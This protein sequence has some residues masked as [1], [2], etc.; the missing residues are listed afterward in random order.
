MSTFSLHRAK[1]PPI[2]A[3]APVEDSS[4][5]Q[6]RKT[7]IPTKRESRLTF[8]GLIYVGVTVFLAIGA[9][10]SQNNLLFWLF[11]VSIATLIV[12]GIF[13]GNALM[14][15]RVHARALPEVA[16]GQ[17]VSLYYS[18]RNRSR[19]FPLFACLLTESQAEN[20]TK[21]FTIGEFSPAA[22]LHLGPGQSDSIVG[23]LV[24]T[25]R[26]RVT[27]R[28][29]RLTT[30]FPFGLLQKSLVFNQPRTLL[31]LPYQLKVRPG[32]VQPRSTVGEQVRRRS[33]RGG[34]S[35][36][37][38]GLREYR[39][40]DPRRKISWKHSARRN[41][42]VVIEHAQT[43]ST[44]VWLFILEP[45]SSHPDH[46][47][48]GE[49]GVAVAAAL[50]EQATQR[51]LPVGL[52][53]PQRG[54][55]AEPATGRAHCGRLLRALA[56]LDRDGPL[57][58]STLP[59]LRTRDQII[60]ISAGDTPAHAANPARIIDLTRPESWLIDSDSLPPTLGGTP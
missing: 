9:I 12:S 22:L 48:L 55:V 39:P 30:R 17:S 11:G 31:V 50:L 5:H 13:S 44:R 25:H 56:T 35:S 1:K 36:E 43:I 33:Q 8:G 42:L 20:G 27:L 59:P 38:W 37:F 6:T 60:Q 3:A 29:L 15:I 19:F 7:S 45:D 10:N 23:T 26:G 49:L 34:N 21:G 57:H 51:R 41:G 16:A 28:T 46:D 52:W 58:Q 32:L 47:T 18:V 54:L 4:T 53:Y 14:K 24:P 2:N 40:G